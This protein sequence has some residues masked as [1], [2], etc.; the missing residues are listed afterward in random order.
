[1]TIRSKPLLM[2]VTVGLLSAVLAGCGRT[3]LSEVRPPTARPTNTPLPVANAPTPTPT[4]A[5]QLTGDPARGQAAFQAQHTLPDN[6]AWACQACH[7][8]GADGAR[9]I[10]PGLWNISNRPY[11]AELGQNGAEYIRT[12]ILNPQEFTAPVTDPSG[13]AWALNMPLGWDQ[14]LTEAEL[15]DIIA[16]LFTLQ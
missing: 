4:E 7:S 8:V 12:S 3:D 2:L 16:Y 14:V 6:S 11:L 13:A 10:G 15:N 9:L 5:I 1:M